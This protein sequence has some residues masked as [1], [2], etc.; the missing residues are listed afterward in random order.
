MPTQDD[1]LSV[2][3]GFY[4]AAAGGCDWRDPLTALKRLLGF[5]GVCL[6]IFDRDG[7]TVLRLWDGLDESTWPAYKAYYAAL[8]PGEEYVR[9]RP[10]RL[11]F[12]T[13]LCTPESE[14]DRDEFYDWKMREQGLCYSLAGSTATDA[15]FNARVPLHRPRSAGHPS[16]SEIALY[17]QLFRHIERALLLAYRLDAAPLQAPTSCSKKSH[18]AS[19]CSTARAACSS[20]TAP[21]GGWPPWP[22]ASLWPAAACGRCAH[23]TTTSC[24]A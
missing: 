11:I 14:I 5:T 7:R 23:A 19:C 8:N 12:Y 4:T 15:P 1:V 22:T 18:T 21:L 3:D 20:P 9:E 6:R 2:I 16:R 24:S 17:A 10:G 13:Y